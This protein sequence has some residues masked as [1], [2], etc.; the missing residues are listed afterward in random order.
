MVV[1]DQS[2]MRFLIRAYVEG[3]GVDVVA[4]A[5]GLDSALEQIDAAAP[6]VVLLDALM[7][8]VDGFE[9]APIIFERR[10]GVR[11]VLLSALVDDRVRA[12]AEAL[13]IH[14]CLSKDQFDRVAATV[15]EVA[16]RSS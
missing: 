11:I 14:A 13:G 6:D 12:K 8:M 16:G 1:D 7:P 4:E 2:D 10:P 5:D 15:R 3:Q 9:A